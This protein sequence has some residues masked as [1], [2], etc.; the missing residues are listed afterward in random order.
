MAGGGSPLTILITQ[1]ELVV[2]EF[3]HLETWKF[4]LPIL[5]PHLLTFLFCVLLL[6]HLYIML[7][8][9]YYFN[10]PYSFFPAIRICFFYLPSVFQT[11][12]KSH[13]CNSKVLIDSANRY[14]TWKAPIFSVRVDGEINREWRW[15]MNS[16]LG[17]VDCSPEV[18]CKKH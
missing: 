11:T 17:A 3:P 12:Q 7:L 18:T 2:T 16:Y 6:F 9:F 15:F 1:K 10:F 5:H 14:S 8:I 4:C 13:H